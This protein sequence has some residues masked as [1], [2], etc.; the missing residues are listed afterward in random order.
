MNA[1]SIP[2]HVPVTRSLIHFSQ[3]CWQQYHYWSDSSSA[4]RPLSCRRMHVVRGGRGNKTKKTRRRK[5]Q[6]KKQ[7]GLVP[8][9]VSRGSDR[10]QARDLQRAPRQRPHGGLATLALPGDPGAGV[11]AEGAKGSGGEEK[12]TRKR[13]DPAGQGCFWDLLL[14]LVVLTPGFTF[15]GWVAK[16][17]LPI[18][19][20]QEPGVRIPNQSKPPIGKLNRICTHEIHEMHR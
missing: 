11:A 12:S 14:V 16:E 10:S 1:R 18:Y 9:V 4:Q 13:P 8:G 5:K 3:P 19:P 7:T 15:S 17:G 20:L 2:K 6:N